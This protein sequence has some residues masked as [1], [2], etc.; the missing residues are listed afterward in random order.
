[1]NVKSIFFIFLAVTQINILF[2]QD[3]FITS[4]DPSAP[5]ELPYDRFIQPAGKQILFGDNELENH[6]L[7]CAISPDGFWLAVQERSSIVIISINEPKI[8]FTYFLKD[9]PGVEGLMNNFSG[10]TWYNFENNLH[11]LWSASGTRNDQSCVI[12]AA[13]TKSYSQ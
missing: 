4:R 2:A 9:F 13:C 3:Y 10:I 7:D 6:A 8:V 12:Q 1:M 5:I 11:L